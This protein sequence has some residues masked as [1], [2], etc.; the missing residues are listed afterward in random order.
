MTTSKF[1]TRHFHDDG[2]AIA[3][4]TEINGKTCGRDFYYDAPGKITEEI[5]WQDGNGLEANGGDVAEA[6]RTANYA[7]KVGPLAIYQTGD[8]ER[9]IAADS[10]RGLSVASDGLG[11]DDLSDIEQTGLTVDPATLGEEQRHHLKRHGWCVT[12]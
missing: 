11:K 2:N 5:D 4:E 9:V 1:T 10:E 8:G 12:D 3:V 6:R 7:I